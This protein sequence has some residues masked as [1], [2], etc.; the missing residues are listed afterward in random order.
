VRGWRRTSRGSRRVLV[1]IENVPLGHD[2]RARKQVG[3]LLGA[4][5]GVCVIS[6]RHPDNAPYR[7]VE[8]LTLYEYRPPP[9]GGTKLSVVLEYLYSW[10][11]TAVLAGRAWFDGGFRA[12][13]VGDPPDT[14]FLLA[15]PFKLL[16][17]AFVV[18]QRD[19]SPE[20]FVERYGGGHRL[21]LW[22]LRTL[23]RASWRTADHVLCVND[24]LRRVVRDRGGLGEGSIT[25]SGNGPSMAATVPRAPR[26]ELKRGARFLVCW[27][28]LMGP[29]DH[30]DLALRAVEEIVDAGGRRDCHFV[31]I[32][33]GESLPELRDRTVR[34]GLCEWVSFTGWLEQDACY[35]YLAT[36]DVGFDSNLQPEVTPVKG[37]EYMAFGL[38]VVAFDLEETR[39]MAGEAGVYVEPGDPVALGRAI[40]ALLDDPLRRAAMGREAR[41]RIER[42][43]SWDRQAPG[44]LAVF[45]RLL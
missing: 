32:G 33:E 31:F 25:V 39:A 34:A 24:S 12:I 1:V 45:E 5:H 26:P 28:G 40:T 13:Q 36:A 44:Y 14:H 20:V 9:E 16:G 17:R 3:A 18:D 29:Q 43:L 23:E 11:V 6:R 37:L 7:R 19:L 2:H 41:S 4:G 38:P 22:I 10:V 21:L 30:V 42:S 8:G 35:D 27:L 15:L